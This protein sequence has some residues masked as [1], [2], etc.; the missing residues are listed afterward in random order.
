MATE[1][2][3]AAAATLDS[4]AAQVALIKAAPITSTL[5]S[6]RVPSQ[7][8]RSR[9]R[10]SRMHKCGPPLSLSLLPLPL[11]TSAATAA[12]Q[13]TGN[14]SLRPDSKV[15]AREALPPVLFRWSFRRS[16][17]DADAPA[18][19]T[20]SRR[21]RRKP[22]QTTL[23]STAANRWRRQISTCPVRRENAISDGFAASSVPERMSCLLLSRLRTSASRS[24]HLASDDDM[25]GNP[26]QPQSLAPRRTRPSLAATPRA[27]SAP[28]FAGSWVALERMPAH[29]EQAFRRHLSGVDRF[30]SAAVAVRGFSP[31]ADR[32]DQP[33]T[34][35]PNGLSSDR[36][37]TAC[38]GRLFPRAR[39]WFG[40]DAAGAILIP[41]CSRIGATTD[42]EASGDGSAIAVLK[43]IRT[44][45]AAR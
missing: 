19:I 35:A 34:R 18:A 12:K 27:R 22:A 36:R 25:A 43:R 2:T 23:S 26:R 28:S 37:Q 3:L 31:T 1:T 45:L 13:D 5:R 40:R 10:A 24:H 44:L 17:H 29:R 9:Y 33:Q 8:T 41:Q 30:G 6:R 21:N 32:S 16:G 14:S 42:A 15:P 7:P 11:P 38:H 4:V 20:N 39:R